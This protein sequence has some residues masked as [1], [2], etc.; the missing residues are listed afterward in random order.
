MYLMAAVSAFGNG[1]SS[2]S[3]KKQGCTRRRGDGAQKCGK[4]YLS[5]VAHGGGAG[6]GCG[7]AADLELL[8]IDENDNS[9]PWGLIHHNELAHMLNNGLGKNVQG[10]SLGDSSES[11][12][13]DLV[14]A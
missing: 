4:G 13:V 11:V 14:Y 5:N 8:E 9:F 2:S 3:S 10:S 7:A 6:A 12:R 1:G